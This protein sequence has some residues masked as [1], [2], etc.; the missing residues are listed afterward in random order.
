MDLAH[1]AGAYVFFHS[2]GAVRPI[3]PMFIEAGIDV[4]LNA[5]PEVD[6]PALLQ[7]VA[8]TAALW[9]AV[10]ANAYGHGI[11]PVA[12]ALAFQYLL[13]HKEIYIG[14]GELIV[15]ER[16]PQPKATPT[17][18][19]INLHSLKDLDILDIGCGAGLLSESACR[20]GGRVHGVDVAER[21]IAIARQ[22][23]RSS[24][25]EIEYEVSTAEALAEGQRRY[26]ESMSTYVR[27]FI[28]Q[29]P[30]PDVETIQNI[31]PAIATRSV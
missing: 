26:V 22:H 31:P 25:L 23:A 7:A 27:Q 13:E 15:G 30:R 24:G 19:E 3:L 18:P 21:N 5:D 29:M 14:D 12:R 11:V 2:D 6:C 16:G 4:Y 8:G 20:L 1:Q 17:Y 10:K 9:P 28:E